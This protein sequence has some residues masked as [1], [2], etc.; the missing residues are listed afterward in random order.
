MHTTRHTKTPHIFLYLQPPFS[1]FPQHSSVS[2]PSFKKLHK[3]KKKKKKKKV[4]PIYGDLTESG[5]SST[6]T[7]T[8]SIPSQ[9]DFHKNLSDTNFS[10]QTPTLLTKDP[11]RY[12]RIVQSRITQILSIGHKLEKKK[13]DINQITVRTIS[14]YELLQNFIHKEL[15]TLYKKHAFSVPY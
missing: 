12:M 2:D 4:D 11:K 9:G 15:C 5:M 3:T 8:F 14:V 7:Q 1:K 10:S 6:S 13:R